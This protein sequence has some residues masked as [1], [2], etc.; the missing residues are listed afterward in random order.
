MTRN[1]EAARVAWDGAAPDW[2]IALAGECD[3]ALSQRQVGD[4]IGYSGSVVNQVL[5]NSYGGDVRKVEEKVRGRFMGKT[6]ECPVIESI[7][8]DHCLRN[9]SLKPSELGVN[10]ERIRIYR[11]CRAGCAH[12]LLPKGVR[13]DQ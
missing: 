2:V 3:R 10:P 5:H 1:V 7:P 12:S 8:R 4:D 9:Q 11:A 13:H 6:V